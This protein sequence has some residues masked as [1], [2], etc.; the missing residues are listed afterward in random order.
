MQRESR[1]ANV[2]KIE[3]M[4]RHEREIREAVEEARLAPRWHAG[5]APSR[6]RFAA[7]PT[8]AQALRLADEIPVVQVDGR[9]VEWP[10]R[11]LKVIAA[12][13]EWCGADTIRA[14]LFRRRYSGEGYISTC[15]GLHIAQATYSVLMFEIRT[16]AIQC[17]CQMQL[18]K[19]F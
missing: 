5:D 6:Q 12:V 3:Y 13:R 4:I 17:A 9:P 19:V 10:E 18:I 7:D 11:W 15:N 8:A 1:D 16:Y 14:E 2:R